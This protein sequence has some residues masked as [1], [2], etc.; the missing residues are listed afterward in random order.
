MATGADF[1]LATSADFSLAIDNSVERG[2]QEP[3]PERRE[4]PGRRSVQQRE[5]AS[6]LQ[7]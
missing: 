6:P 2:L 1:L 4:S 5:I 3:I 7:G